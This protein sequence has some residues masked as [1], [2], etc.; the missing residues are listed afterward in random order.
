MRRDDDG[1][2][3]ERR[4]IASANPVLIRIYFDYFPVL[5]FFG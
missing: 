4:C 2:A 5:Q 3:A 1:I